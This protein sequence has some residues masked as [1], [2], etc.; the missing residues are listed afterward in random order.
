MGCLTIKQSQDSCK[1]QTPGLL[2][3]LG[4][5]RYSVLETHISERHIFF[6]EKMICHSVMFYDLLEENPDEK[7]LSGL[8]FSENGTFFPT[9]AI[10]SRGLRSWSSEF[11]LFEIVKAK[12]GDFE[13]NHNFRPIHGFH[14]SDKLYMFHEDSTNQIGLTNTARGPYLSLRSSETWIK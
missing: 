8:H 1:N 7:R 9:T 3:L 14:L 2:F 12:I 13:I 4:R 5:H 11:T 10:K 6:M